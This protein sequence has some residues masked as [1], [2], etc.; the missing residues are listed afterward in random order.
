[1]P[2]A[3]R[4][5]GFAPSPIYTRQPYQPELAALHNYATHAS[6]CQ[7][8]A[9]PYSTHLNGSTLCPKGHAH[10]RAVATYVF[11]HEGQAYSTTDVENGAQRV[12]IEIPVG[13]EVV[14]ELLAAMERGLRLRA[15]ED[16]VISYDRNYY[17]PARPVISQSQPP[18][19]PTN[20]STTTTT[21]PSTPTSAQRVEIVE[22]RREQRRE[23]VQIVEVAR[24]RRE[25]KS[26]KTY[27]PGRGS[28]YASDIEERRRKYIED[29]YYR[30]PT[31]SASEYYDPRFYR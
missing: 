15:R 8:C 13:C 21:T 24:R 7:T 29:G 20:L 16:K 28:L 12:Q 26:E 23:R 25:R 22:P 31:Q 30:Q 1:M 3:V 5:V 9:H 19:S 10:A 14:R 17:I 18:R 11:N 4:Q 6:H 27:I 2:S